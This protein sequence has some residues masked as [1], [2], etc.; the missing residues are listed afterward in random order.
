MMDKKIGVICPIV[1]IIL[2]M[3]CLIYNAINQEN[4]IIW[5]LFLFSG[6]LLLSTNVSRYNKK[7]DE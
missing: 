7:E 1:Q 6:I 4:I 5:I 2:S 3:I